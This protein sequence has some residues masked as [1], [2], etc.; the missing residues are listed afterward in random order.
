M[1]RRTASGRAGLPM[2]H[3]SSHKPASGRADG[4]TLR[5]RGGGQERGR[6]GAVG[7]PRGGR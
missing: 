2:S 3:P 1:Q 4:S 5:S 7:A 6:V